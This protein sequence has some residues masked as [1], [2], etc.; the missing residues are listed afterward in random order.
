MQPEKIPL[1]KTHQFSQLLLDYLSGNTK[2]QPFYSADPVLESFASQIEKKQLDPF[3]RS[4]LSEV[5][6]EQYSGIGAKAPVE[7]NIR[8]QSTFLS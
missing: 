3:I 1:A 2:L 5:L 8:I 7:N 6:V 4:T